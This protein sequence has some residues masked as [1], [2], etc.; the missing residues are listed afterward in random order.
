MV[1]TPRWD[2]YSTLLSFT[3][4]Q[5]PR[6]RGNNRRH[7]RWL[8]PSLSINSLSSQSP[9]AQP[10]QPSSPNLLGKPSGGRAEAVQRP[11]PLPFT[12]PQPWLTQP[13]LIPSAADKK[14]TQH[15]HICPSLCPER[16]RHWAKTHKTAYPNCYMLWTPRSEPQVMWKIS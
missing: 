1:H 13:A 15:A 8:F 14:R 12:E 9:A 4:T 5:A 16:G 6:H 10:E 3:G 2:F 11:A 7:L